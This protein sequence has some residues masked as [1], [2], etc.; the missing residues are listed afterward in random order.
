MRAVKD[1]EPVD[2]GLVANGVQLAVV[3][4][5]LKGEAGG[6]FI[7]CIFFC[8]YMVCPSHLVAADAVVAGGG[9]LADD[10]AVLLLGG[11]AELRGGEGSVS[12]SRSRDKRYMKRP[13]WSFPTL[14]LCSWRILAREGSPWKVAAG[15]W[16]AAAARA[17][18]LAR[19]KAENCL[20][21]TQEN[22]I[23]N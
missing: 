21:F 7:K 4:D 22:V 3:A 1:A 2:A 5:V 14:N 11:V 9:L 8:M 12:W 23:R 17:T 19:K 6:G 13:T 18:E 15:N 10:D 16:G 20:E